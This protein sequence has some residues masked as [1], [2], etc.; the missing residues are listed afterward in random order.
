MQFWKFKGFSYLKN[1]FVNKVSEIKTPYSAQIELTLRCMAK[2]KFCSIPSIPKSLKNPEMTTD[3]VKTIIDQIAD[4][5]VVALSFTGGEPTLRK[6]LP[7]LIRYTG[8]KKNLTTG[9]ATNG[10]YIPKLLKKKLLCG[11]DYILLSLDFPVPELHDKMRG[12]DVYKKVIKSIELAHSQNINVIIS[13]NVMKSNLKYLPEI[14][15]LAKR[16]DCS[17]ELYPCEN[18][19]RCYNGRKYKAEKVEELIP[20]LHLWAKIIK[21]LYEDYK[22]VITDFFSIDTIEKGGFGGDPKYQHTLR[23]HVAEAYLFVRHNG[24]IDFPCKI[25]PLISFNALKYPLS[26]I[27]RSSKVINIMKKHD[28]YDFCDHCRLGCALASSMTAN[29]STIYEKYIKNIFRGNLR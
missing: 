19:I 6:D 28:S 13:T 20:N 10:Y 5:G 17:I 29:W 22:N 23:C 18:I 24:F 14:C 26:S 3:Q 1:Y 16:L 15:E 2:C 7:E 9:L 8:I 4:L 12:I 21:R 11:L 27:Y 25:N